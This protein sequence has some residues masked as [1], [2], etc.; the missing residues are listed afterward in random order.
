MGLK[1]K[2]DITTTSVGV[3]DNYIFNHISGEYKG[4]GQTIQAWKQMKLKLDFVYINTFVNEV[5][6]G[7]VMIIINAKYTILVFLDG[8]GILSLMLLKKLNNSR[9][10]IIDSITEN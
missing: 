5:Y 2:I 8:K 9:E 3:M 10:D 1:S 6:K 7:F 4:V